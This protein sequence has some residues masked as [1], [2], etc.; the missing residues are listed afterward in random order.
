MAKIFESPDKGETVYVRDEGSVGRVLY[1]E[2]EKRRTLH[3][4]I[5]ESQ[6]WARIHQAA[7]TNPSLQEALNRVKVA[8]Y[9]TADYDKYYGNRKNTK[10]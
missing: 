8:Y 7:K 1:A 5:K 3:D 2:S 10:T 6:F 4:D 9:L